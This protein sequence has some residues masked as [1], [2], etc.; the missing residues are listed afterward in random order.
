[1]QIEDYGIWAKP[2]RVIKVGGEELDIP[3]RD[4]LLSE[5]LIYLPRESQ[6]TVELYHNGQNVGSLTR[7]PGSPYHLKTRRVY[8]VMESWEEEE[9]EY[10]IPE[11]AT[12][13]YIVQRVKGAL[14][15]EV[16]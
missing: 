3:E 12:D 4:L 13:E 10:A 5:V 2:G 14:A 16:D 1:M 7:Y 11:D 9:G 15:N 8:Q 6:W